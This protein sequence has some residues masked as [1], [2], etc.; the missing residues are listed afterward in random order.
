MFVLALCLVQTS[1]HT[2]FNMNSKNWYVYVTQI[3]EMQHVYKYCHH[4][5]RDLP[6]KFV[7]T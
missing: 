6:G 3:T 1:D 5:V 2:A 7:L 4:S